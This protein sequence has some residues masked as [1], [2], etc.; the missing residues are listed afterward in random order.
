MHL[1]ICAIHSDFSVAVAAYTV[2]DL[3]VLIIC[4]PFFKSKKEN[5][6]IKLLSYHPVLYLYTAFPYPIGRVRNKKL[7]DKIDLYT[8]T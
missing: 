8:D 4:Q 7:T 5:I 1:L 3:V 6:K 2:N